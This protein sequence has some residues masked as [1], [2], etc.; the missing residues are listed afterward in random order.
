MVIKARRLN[1][2]TFSLP[3]VKNHRR[4]AALPLLLNHRRGNGL[5]LPRAT[6]NDMVLGHALEG[7]QDDV[8]IELVSHLGLTN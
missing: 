4:N 2:P 3:P 5:A 1:D 8:F 6:V 7:M